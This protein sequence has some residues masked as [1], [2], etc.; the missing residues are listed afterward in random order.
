MGKYFENQRPWH[1]LNCQGVKETIKSRETPILK[2]YSCLRFHYEIYWEKITQLIFESNSINIKIQKNTF[3]IILDF[4]SVI[5]EEI[6]DFLCEIIFAPL[7]LCL[8]MAIYEIFSHPE[9][10]RYK[11]SVFSKATLTLIIILIVTFISPL[12]IV[13]RSYGKMFLNINLDL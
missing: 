4:V 5:S 6:I 8:K 13:Y 2:I 3:K 12:F 7:L 1:W 10:R 9:L 11:A